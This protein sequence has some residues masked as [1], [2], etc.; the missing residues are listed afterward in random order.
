LGLWYCV[1][2]CVGIGAGIVVRRV[3][4]RLRYMP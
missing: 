3:M 4:H 1:I 2:G